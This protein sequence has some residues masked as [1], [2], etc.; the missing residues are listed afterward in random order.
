MTTSP[1]NTRKPASVTDVKRSTPEVAEA[2]DNFATERLVGMT[3]NMPRD[4]HKEFKTRA[5]VEGIPM[6]DLLIRCFEA[7][8]KSQS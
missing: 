2:A 7:Y 4:W 1:F 5:V 3:F 8:K 6:R